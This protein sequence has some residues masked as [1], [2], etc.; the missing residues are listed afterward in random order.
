MAWAGV[1][2]ALRGIAG[3]SLA[4]V[5]RRHRGNYTCSAS[6]GWNNNTTVTHTV[7]IDVQCE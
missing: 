7:F 2:G 5:T 6:N 3:L 1:R 4:S